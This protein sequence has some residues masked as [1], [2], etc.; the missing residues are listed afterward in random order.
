I[1][2]ARGVGERI[3][4]DH[5]LSWDLLGMCGISSAIPLPICYLPESFPGGPGCPVGEPHTWLLSRSA[6]D[7]RFGYLRDSWGGRCTVG[8]HLTWALPLTLSGQY[9]YASAHSITRSQAF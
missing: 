9:S 3:W 1:R 7:K 2:G 5:K 6:C 8:A 4:K